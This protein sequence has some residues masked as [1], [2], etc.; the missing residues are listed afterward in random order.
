MFVS[1]SRP[2]DRRRQRESEHADRKTYL[3]LSKDND[4]GNDFVSS[5]SIRFMSHCFRLFRI[6]IIQINFP[7]LRRWF[8]LVVSFWI[9]ILF[10]RSRWRW[11]FLFR[12][13]CCSFSQ[14]YLSQQ[15]QL[16]LDSLFRFIEISCRFFA[17]PLPTFCLLLLIDKNSFFFCSFSVVVMK[18]AHIA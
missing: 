11:V 6:K 12:I 1:T 9:I 8:F 10:L 18:N 16:F 3:V 5:K 4:K 14:P 17:E 13:T 15:N 7:L 2:I